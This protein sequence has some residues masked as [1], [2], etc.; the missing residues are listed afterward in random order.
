MVKYFFL[1]VLL[2]NS[3]FL[4]AEILVTGNPKEDL[5]STV[6]L[7]LKSSYRQFTVKNN[8][9]Y[10]ATGI[11]A[12]WYAFEHDD[13]L[14]NHSQQ[15]EIKSH[16]DFVGDMGIAFNF[17]ILH[18]SMYYAGKNTNNKKLMQFSMEYAAA[19]YLTLAETG[20]LSY[21]SIHERPNK[22]GL[23]DWE[24]KFRADSS[25]PSGHI[26]PYA[27]LFFKTLQFYGPVYALGPAVLTLWSGMQ[28]VREGRHYHSD[29]IS[30]FFLTGLAS[31]GVR[32]VAGYD[33][34]NSLYKWVFE[35][36]AQ[37]SIIKDRKRAGARISFTY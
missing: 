26:V 7:F 22:E 9:F 2:V 24:T 28:R 5:Y 37:V 19:M 31:E 10:G 13:R 8:L 27:A 33:G 35:H 3:T 32:A 4:K 1:L 18:L 16:V 30:S 29:V 21:I 15:K 6:D 11:G 17:P 36:Q 23:S 20:I 34:N 12:S 14:S 25:W